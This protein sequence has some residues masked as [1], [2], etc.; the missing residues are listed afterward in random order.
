MVFLNIIAWTTL[1]CTTIYL[2][3]AIWAINA[4]P[5][6]ELNYDKVRQCFVICVPLIVVSVLWLIYG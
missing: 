2:G 1:V 4:T 5:A 6:W 3:L